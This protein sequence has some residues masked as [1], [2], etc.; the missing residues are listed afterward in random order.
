MTAVRF[1]PQYCHPEHSEGSQFI[2]CPQRR[3]FTLSNPAI[4]F[5]MRKGFARHTKSMFF[6]VFSTTF[7][8]A[9]SSQESR[10]QVAN[11]VRLAFGREEAKTSVNAMLLSAGQNEPSAQFSPRCC[12][13]PSR[14]VPLRKQE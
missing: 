8:E 7:F 10:D 4:K 3:A 5:L 13:S 14:Q 2:N 12:M 1:S 6:A 9:L 11:A